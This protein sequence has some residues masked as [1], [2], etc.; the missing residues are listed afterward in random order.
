MEKNDFS[1]FKNIDLS[2]KF[3][4]ITG[5]LGNIG[6][7]IIETLFELNSEVIIIDFDSEINRNKI[8]ILEKKYKKKIDFYN[9]DLSKKEDIIKFCDLIKI[10][11]TKI[12]IL[13]HAAAL[14]TASNLNGWSEPFEKQSLEAFDLCM[15]IN[16]KSIL[17]MF[18]NLLDLFKKSTCAKVI[19]IS[20]IY[21]IRG[22]DF[23]LYENTTMQSP[24]AYSV[25]KAS[26]NIA[27]KYLA[28]LYGKY[29]ICVNS[30]VL[31][32]IFR[33]QNSNF[34]NKY[35]EK[36]PLGR[37]GTEED[38]KGIISYLSSNLSNY[39]TGQNIALDGG[40]TCKV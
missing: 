7:K 36:V 16:T 17:L 3:A 32:G 33:N 38:I 6:V 9:T 12:D 24:I 23:S 28:S 37:M 35:N 30:I 27:V 29:N 18:Q 5:G 10:K 20:S 2:N 22:N 19:F 39:M 26:L 40:L 34:V 11:Y 13:I 15:D 8:N 21:G 4:I 31:G 1:I 25:S 14:V